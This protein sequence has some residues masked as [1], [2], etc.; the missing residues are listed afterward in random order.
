[1]TPPETIQEFL[2]QPVLALAGASRT[3][4]RFG[5]AVLR[6]LLR[7]GYRVHPLHPEAPLLE[8]Q[9]CAASPADLPG[10][11]GGLVVVVPPAQALGLVEAAARAGIRRVWL[12]PGADAP[13][14][15][16]HARAQG[17]AVISG[18]CILMHA[19][20]TGLHRLHR[21]LWSRL[22]AGRARS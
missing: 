12:Q 11:V 2:A 9:P 13:E 6:A 15:V 19:Q 20:P 14:V 16:A 1:M 18:T 7:K 5:S 3:G 10:D 17:L 22:G 8:G 21:W 4:R